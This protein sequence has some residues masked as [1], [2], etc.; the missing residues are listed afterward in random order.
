MTQTALHKHE[1]SSYGAQLSFLLREVELA[2]QQGD[3]A[4]IRLLLSL[5]ESVKAA[6]KHD[7]DCR[8]VN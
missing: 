7:L 5:A 6:K 1:M 3:K 4:R 8:V 2:R